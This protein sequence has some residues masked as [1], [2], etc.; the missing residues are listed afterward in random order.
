ML[1]LCLSSS[2]NDLAMHQRHA[3][4]SARSLKNV[5]VLMIQAQ[6]MQ[7]FHSMN[8]TLRLQVSGQINV[9]SML[10]V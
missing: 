10:S 5:L 2:M 3:L 9:R 8:D 7:C 4:A 6:T 1:P